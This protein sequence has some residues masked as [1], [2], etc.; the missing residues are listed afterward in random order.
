MTD[1]S[2]IYPGMG[3]L[4]AVLCFVILTYMKGFA[5]PFVLCLLVLAGGTFIV[6][7]AGELEGFFVFSSINFAYPGI[8]LI[9][10]LMGK[11]SGSR[12]P[13]LSALVVA[14][15]WLIPMIFAIVFALRKHDAERTGFI[16]FFK[17]QTG[18][19][20]FLYAA[21]MI[22]WLFR[23]NVINLTEGDVSQFIPFATLSGYIE[24]LIIKNI[25]FRVFVLYLLYGG[26][27]FVPFGF[28]ISAVM[29]KAHIAFRLVAVLLFPALT[30]C[31]QLWSG[32]N[33]FDID[34][35]I[36]GFVGGSIGLLVFHI[37]DTVFSD[38]CGRGC[39]GNVKRYSFE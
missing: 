30:E 20:G 32:K 27:I 13:K 28:L 33:I 38:V 6:F 8:R 9:F 34:D 17:A 5:L 7:K 37:L 3:I 2:S 1:S 14:A 16:G 24:A 35:I 19:L 21:F 10:D 15:S 23:Y 18:M 4:S 39:T 11:T 36:L 22:F 31:V 29:G 26:G 12:D 25:S